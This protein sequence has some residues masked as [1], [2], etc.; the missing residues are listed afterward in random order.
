[1]IQI[2]DLIKHAV[3]DKDVRP[4]RN[5]LFSRTNVQGYNTLKQKYLQK[6]W[7]GSTLDQTSISVRNK[8]TLPLDKCNLTMDNSPETSKRQV[9]FE[10]FDF[11]KIPIQDGEKKS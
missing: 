11:T 6:N 4:V 5:H 7:Q 3:P 1:M 9:S 2:K 10:R 8:K